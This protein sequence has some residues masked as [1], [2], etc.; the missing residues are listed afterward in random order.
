M[1]ML[2]YTSHRPPLI[3]IR[4]IQHIWLVKVMKCQVSS[5][6]TERGWGEVWITTCIEKII[7]VIH[8]TEISKAK[9]NK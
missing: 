7:I 6:R 1:H 9:T 8:I 3:R 2:I 4:P 5:I